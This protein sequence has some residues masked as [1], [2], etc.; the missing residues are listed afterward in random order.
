MRKAVR[1]SI[2]CALSALFLGLATA[3]HAAPIGSISCTGP[4]LIKPVNMQISYLDLGVTSPTT[5]INGAVGGGRPN[6]R[7][8]VIHISINQASTAFDLQ[9]T[10][11]RLE[12]CHVKATMNSASVEIELK[13]VQFQNTELT[14]AP[15]SLNA[16]ARAFTSVSLSYADFHVVTI[17]TVGGASDD[18]GTP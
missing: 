18:G 6:Y 1:H 17:G 12:T 13:E 14:V 10:N 5:A 15:A 16:A 4:G 2:L 7:P 11:R 8:L 3:A 9:L